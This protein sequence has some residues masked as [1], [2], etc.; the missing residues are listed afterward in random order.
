MKDVSKGSVHFPSPPP[1]FPMER[2]A[3][4]GSKCAPGRE[5]RSIQIRGLN[6]AL[7]SIPWDVS[8]APAKPNAKRSDP[9]NTALS[10]LG[11]FTHHG[12]IAGYA[13]PPFMV[14]MATDHHSPAAC[15]S[16]LIL[17]L[18]LGFPFETK[19]KQVPSSSAIPHFHGFSSGSDIPSSL[20]APCFQAGLPGSQVLLLVS[21]MSN[22]IPYPGKLDKTNQ[23][24]RHLLRKSVVCLSHPGE[25]NNTQTYEPLWRKKQQQKSK[26]ICPVLIDALSLEAT[27]ENNTYSSA[28]G[29]NQPKNDTRVI[30]R[31]GPCPF[32]A[33]SQLHV[34]PAL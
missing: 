29:G 24:Q 30:S 12:Q 4:Q 6:N 21:P 20:R 11:G 2:Y 1:W 14:Y 27:V 13:G 8:L 17:L 33:A 18:P 25:K 5:F 28:N 26:N 10:F 34:L 32:C 9:S 15:R 23:I 16:L 31:L 3:P 7:L 22:E 19:V